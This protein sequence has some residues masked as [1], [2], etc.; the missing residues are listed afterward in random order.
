V[1][2]QGG[3]GG[4][5]GV[6]LDGVEEMSRRAKGRKGN[7]KLEGKAAGPEREEEEKKGEGG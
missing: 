5:V 6:S 4:G 7:L 2:V 3:V 1:C